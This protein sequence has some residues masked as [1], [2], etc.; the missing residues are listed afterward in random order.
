MTIREARAKPPAAPSSAAPRPVGPAALRRRPLA[1]LFV[2][3]AL[4]SAFFL[5]FPDADI[6]VS[7][8]FFTPGEGFRLAEDPAMLL[9]R[10]IGESF[11]IA[12]VAVSLGILVLPL[13]RRGAVLRWLKP[14]AALYILAVYILGPALLVNALFKNS[15]GRARP[16]EI[17]AF[18]H[19][20]LFSPVWTVSTACS[21]NCSFVSGEG[22]AAAAL[23]CLLPLVPNRE[24]GIVAVSLLA[25]AASV[26]AARVAMGAHFLSDTMLSW[27][28]VL[29]VAALMK[30]LIL[31]R[32]AARIDDAFLVL[33]E[34]LWAFRRACR[35][36]WRAA[37][38]L[39]R[40]R[41]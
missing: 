35:R 30:P 37:R 36:R 20:A 32:G 19:D 13:L 33:S 26:S 25:I 10:E 12:I 8:W 24:R 14:H 2:A 3:T 7:R 17:A 18:G 39:R 27:L 22:A 9:V 6:A 15:F 40:A 4:V 16:R 38:D 31:E 5:L 34:R 21:G 41:G 23:L 28:L 1:T 29:T 11:T